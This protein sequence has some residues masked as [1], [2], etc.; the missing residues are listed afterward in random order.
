[1]TTVDLTAGAAVFTCDQEI[2]RVRALT[3]AARRAANGDAI[4]LSNDDLDA[5]VEELDLLTGQ[6][7]KP[8]IK[9]V[10]RA[11]RAGN[12]Y[13]LQCP[14]A[15]AVVHLRE[16]LAAGEIGAVDDQ[17]AIGYLQLA[18]HFCGRWSHHRL[19]PVI[20]RSLCN[21]FHHA[22]TMLG[23]ASHL[24]DH[25]TAI[26]I[27]AP[28]RQ[29]QS[30]DLYVNVSAS[31]RLSVEVKAPKALFW[32]SLAPSKEEIERCMRKE[33]QAA[34]N[35]LTGALGGI[36]VIG[37][38]HPEPAVGRAFS[39]CIEEIMDG[40]RHV[41]SRIAAI[42][43][44]FFTSAFDIGTTPTSATF[45]QQCAVTVRLNPKFDGPNPVVP[46]ERPRN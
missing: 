7:F 27:T 4:S 30:P 29:G 43:G 8:A 32:P 19:F 24:D 42:A 40:K 37:G 23:I 46:T 14:P 6:S 45:Q 15:W 18:R 25:G 38:S 36:V 34:R 26:G 11:I 9:S 17:H 2:E 12:H 44:V 31:D 39:E 5:M 16:R 1:M 22:M 10:E 28:V 13:F 20:G 35:Q 33:L 21:E 41:S 3:G